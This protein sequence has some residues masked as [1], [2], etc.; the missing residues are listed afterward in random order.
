MIAATIVT[1][2]FSIGHFGNGINAGKGKPYQSFRFIFL[3][4]MQLFAT[5]VILKSKS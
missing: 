3:L 4:G 1:V 2:L 5:Y